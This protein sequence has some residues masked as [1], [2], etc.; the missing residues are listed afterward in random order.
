MCRN[1]PFPALPRRRYRIAPVLA[2]LAAV[3]C[4]APRPAYADGDRLSLR[5]LET[6]PPEDSGDPLR[7]YFFVAAV[8]VYPKLES[9]APVN[10]FLEPVLRGLAPGH[11]GVQTIGELRD[12]HALWPPHLGLGVNLNQYWSVFV[13]AGYTA[14]KVRTK[15]NRTSLFLLPLH[16]DF[17]IYRSALFTG[18]GVDY[19]PWGMPPQMEYTDLKSRLTHIRPFLGSRLTWTYATFKAKVKLGL[20]P[21]P[22]L[23]NIEL[24]DAWTLPSLTA[25]GGFDLPLSRNSTLTFNGGYNFFREQEFDFE[26][27]AFTV[28]WRRYFKG[29]QWFQKASGK[30]T[31]NTAGPRI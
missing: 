11:G 12:N 13:E 26:G 27:Y 10:Q 3:A 25:V 1:P 6:P 15:N 31:I 30:R 28:Q 17:E 8:N 9:E 5:G 2:L 14:G 19:Y 18:L 21:L 16:T 23:V 7:W 20:Q 22:N 4:L 24:S 29:P